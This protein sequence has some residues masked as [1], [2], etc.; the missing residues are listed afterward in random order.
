[1][2]AAKGAHMSADEF[3]RKYWVVWSFNPVNLLM[4]AGRL[5][6]KLYVRIYLFQKC[7]PCHSTCAMTWN[8]LYRRLTGRSELR[9]NSYRLEMD[10]HTVSYASH[11]YFQWFVPV[12]CF[13]VCVRACKSWIH[14]WFTRCCIIS[15]TYSISIPSLLHL[16]VW[17]LNRTVHAL[18]IVKFWLACKVPDNHG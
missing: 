7:L 15:K 10:N 9:D 8:E 11:R 5:V 17:T 14:T 4:H 2:N 13:D 18:F 16:H 6:W 1:M 12:D 3:S